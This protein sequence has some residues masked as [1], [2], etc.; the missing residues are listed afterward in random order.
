MGQVLMDLTLFKNA[1]STAPTSVVVVTTLDTEG[2]P[3]GFTAGS[4]SS[5]SLDPPLILVSLDCKAECHAA[6]SQAEHFAVSVLRPEQQ[7]LARLMATRGA[8]KF[9][10]RHFRQGPRGLPL[11]QGAVST[12]VCRTSQR[13]PAGDHTILIGCVEEVAVGEASRALVHF[14]RDFHAVEVRGDAEQSS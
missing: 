10:D 12:F 6:F 8:E 9:T 3:R 2:R 11:A 4:F 7:Q 1:L 13:H 5:L 14:Q